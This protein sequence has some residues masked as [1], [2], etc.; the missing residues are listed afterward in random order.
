MVKFN[1][2]FFNKQAKSNVSTLV[3]SRIRPPV[4]SSS[5]ALVWRA[6]QYWGGSTSVLK[7][8]RSIPLEGYATGPRDW[9]ATRRMCDRRREPCKVVLMDL[10]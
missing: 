5:R 7:D 10:Y 4:R 1:I 3:T 8:Y 2:Y 6:A 9:G